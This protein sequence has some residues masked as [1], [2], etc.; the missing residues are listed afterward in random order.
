VASAGS[1]GWANLQWP[2]SITHI[3]GTGKTSDIYGQVWIDGVTSTP[4]ATVGLKAWVG[5]GTGLDAT[6]WTHWVVAAFNVDA[7]NND[8][9]VGALEPKYGGTYN[10]AYRYSYLGDAYVYGELNGPTL[11]ILQNPGIL[12][13]FGPAPPVPEP[14]TL[15]LLGFGLAV[16]GLSRRRKA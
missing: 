3:V 8:E 7:G 1:I 4:G 6:A 13:V 11:G 2:P 10:Y 14:G 15:A 9:F 16:L 12:T 5:F